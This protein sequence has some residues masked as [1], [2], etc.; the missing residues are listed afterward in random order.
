[1]LFGAIPRRFFV[2]LPTLSTSV[3]MTLVMLPSF[4]R[5]EE[6]V[7]PVQTPVVRATLDVTGEAPNLPSIDSLDRELL[8]QTGPLGDG[9]EVLRGT[10][11]VSLGRMGG[12]GLEPTIRGL[13]Q[14]NINILLDGALGPSRAF[15]LA[16]HRW[17]VDDGIRRSMAFLPRPRRP[18]G[19]TSGHSV[20]RSVSSAATGG[21]VGDV[22]R[23]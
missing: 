14:T 8:D 16:H 5:A 17:A 11:G 12:H 4:A 1:M 2:D 3:L 10:A 7:D 23:R 13:A 15:D 20:R 18:A 22:G 19:R 9:A 6:T 21:P